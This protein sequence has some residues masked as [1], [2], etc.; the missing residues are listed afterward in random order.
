MAEPESPAPT[1]RFQLTK[2]I[3][4]ICVFVPAILFLVW[5]G[6]RTLLLLVLVI[7]ARGSWEFY[8]LLKS[9]G[10]R[11]ATT[12]GMVSA[13]ALV[14]HIYLRP[15]ATLA[16]PVSL[17]V[18]IGLAA[19]LRRG[20][21][22]YAANTSA[23]FGGAIL[24]GLLGGAPLLIVTAAPAE[25]SAFLVMAIFASI[26]VTDAAAYIGGNL[27]GKG[28]LAPSISPN[29]TRIGFLTG[30][31]GG[32]VPLLFRDLLPMFSTAELAGLLIVASAGGQLG[33]LVES[34]WKR[35]VGVKDS[36]A[37]IPGHGGVLDRFDSYF[38]AFPLTY[39]YLI[40]LRSF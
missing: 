28:K 33:D 9:A 3:A 20:T 12:V 1:A 26:W 15:D 16:L 4:S 31:I 21:E 40:T 17:V 6:N 10:Y 27:W 18:L 30:L 35:D 37:L 8:H 19:G 25:D 14:L 29:K 39:V 32:M 23:T 24:F 36:P 7:V 5:A 22:R 13:A 2:R 11:P 38:F 34:A